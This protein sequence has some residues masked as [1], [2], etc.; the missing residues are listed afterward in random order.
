MNLCP[1]LEANE[2][3]TQFLYTQVYINSNCVSSM[4]FVYLETK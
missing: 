4:I 2:L 3:W 1:S